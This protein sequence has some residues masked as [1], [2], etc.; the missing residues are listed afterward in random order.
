[1]LTLVEKRASR[2]YKADGGELAEAAVVPPPVQLN[3]ASV[4]WVGA[5]RAKREAARRS[6]AMP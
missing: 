5:R 4:F 6:M 3:A 2:G 1:M